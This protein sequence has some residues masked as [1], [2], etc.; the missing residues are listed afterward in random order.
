MPARVRFA[1]IPFLLSAPAWGQP[2]A[3]RPSFDAASIKAVGG[4]GSER[5]RRENIQV[6]PGSVTL[7]NVSLKAAIRWAYGVFDY[8]V[9]GPA[10]LANDRFDI[11]AKSA[12]PASEAELRL[13]LQTLLADRFQVKVHHSTKELSVYALVVAKDGPKFRPSETEGESSI[14][15]NQKEL[16]LVV[17][18]TQLSQLVE[19]LAN[20]AQLP[21]VDLTGLKGRYDVTVD[22]SKYIMDRTANEPLDP[23]S[24]I[25]RG[26]QDELGLKLE[27]RKMPVDLVVVDEA[28]RT[29]SEN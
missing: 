6:S 4:D 23:L 22:L 24:L 8:Q 16:K 13:M 21:V 3:A 1:L 28:N 20:I 25:M 5:R 27:S 19:M 26:L 11:V 12:G 14:E 18:R 9:S 15:P 10:R 29:A 17:H 7:T 2:A